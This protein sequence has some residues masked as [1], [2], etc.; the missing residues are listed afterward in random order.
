MASRASPV[1]INLELF[2]IYLPGKSQDR[3][4]HSSSLL[5]SV[6]NPQPS[7]SVSIIIIFSLEKE[8]HL[9][10]VSI[11]ICFHDC[12]F[13]SKHLICCKCVFFLWSGK[14]LIL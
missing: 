6:N 7:D 5:E 9:N 1:E 12:V 3:T 13:S 4:R 8:K 11:S 10:F 14:G 2:D